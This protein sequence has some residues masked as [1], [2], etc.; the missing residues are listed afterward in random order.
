MARRRYPPDRLPFVLLSAGPAPN[1]PGEQPCFMSK[2][3]DLD[4]LLAKVERLAPLAP[5]HLG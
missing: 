1:V 4:E 2:P 5:V 3:L